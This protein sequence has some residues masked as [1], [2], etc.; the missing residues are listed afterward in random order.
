MSAVDVSFLYREHRGAPQHVG[1]IGVFEPDPD[2]FDYDRLIALL[3]ERIS[4]VPRYRQKVRSVPGHLAYPVWID[5]PSFD[6][7]YHVRR[8]ALPRPGTDAQLLEFAARIQ[9]R[10]LDRNRPLWEIYLVEGLQHDRVAIIT[11]THESM[12]DGADA[13]DILHVMLDPTAQPRRTIEALWMPQPEPST[14]GLVADAITAAARRPALALHAAR[15]GVRD[16]R[17]LAERVTDVADGAVRAGVSAV[18]RASPG[19]L[20][21]RIGEQRRMAVA[22]T[23]LDDYRAVRAAH[24]GTV[25]DVMLATVTGA[26]RTWLRQRG[27]PVTPALTIRA[28]VPMSVTDSD[29]GGARGS[30][31]SAHLV[32]LPVGEPDPVRRL[33]QLGFALT[34]Q[35]ESG[36]PVSAGTLA[37]LAGFA[38]P[39]L[40]AM[41]AR[42]ASSVARR[43]FSIVVTNVPGPQFPLYAA[44]VRMIEMFPITPLN[45]GQPLSIGITSYDSRVY[46]GINGDRDAIPDIAELAEQIAPA[47]AELVSASPQAPE[48]GRVRVRRPAAR[49]SRRATSEEPQP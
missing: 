32:D 3:E 49:R 21:T 37:S 8:S 5:D 10:M 29:D 22:R 15:Q 28:L 26:L 42:A 12:I 18:R 35:R 39:T 23:G 11:K 34:G 6:V 17:V 33:A 45:A 38:P 14:T 27:Y 30:R 25:N 47:L 19:P 20:A 43:P 9:S 2:G 4:L 48:G 24:G 41:G 46:F 13:V 40:H 16:V 7:T 44:G 31:V 36:H 1:S